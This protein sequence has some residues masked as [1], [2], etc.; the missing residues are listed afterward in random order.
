MKRFYPLLILVAMPLL[1]QA[2]N[3][4]PYILAFESSNSVSS[5]KNEI[6][7]ALEVNGI[8]ILG[9][10]RPAN[11]NNRWVIVISSGELM[12]A[13]KKTGGLTGFAASQRLAITSENGKT[14]VSYTNPYYWGNAYFRDDFGSVSNYYNSFNNKL[15]GAMHAS[16]TYIGRGFGSEDGMS[17]KELRK[18]QYMLGMP[19]FYDTVKLGKFSSYSQAVSRIDRNISS[20]I[21]DVRKVYKIEIPGK[22]LCLYGFALGGEK[23]ESKFLPTIDIGDPKHTAFLPYELLVI[24]DEVHMLHGRYRIALSFPDLTM[25]TFTKIMST[26][27]NI[28]DLLKRAVQ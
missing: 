7:S 1:L 4:K 21:T 16:G 18:Y 6:Q 10:Y 2:Q 3:L 19:Y 8:Q 24:G 12:S 23:G 17:S 22:S 9:Q 28:E 15:L 14:R 20:G 13:V 25:G 5:V 26:P 11:D 27:G